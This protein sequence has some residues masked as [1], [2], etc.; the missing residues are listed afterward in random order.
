[1]Y[2]CPVSKRL[3][4]GAVGLVVEPEASAGDLKQEDQS[5]SVLN[6]CTEQVD[7]MFVI[8]IK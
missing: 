2:E 6:L 3:A 4:I 7:N 5:C 1:M 8:L